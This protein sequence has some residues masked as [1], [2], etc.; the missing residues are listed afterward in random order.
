MVDDMC[1]VAVGEELVVFLLGQWRGDI[2]E[3]KLVGKKIIVS[4]IRRI[5]VRCFSGADGDA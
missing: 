1:V 2:K 3:R 4:V 5:A